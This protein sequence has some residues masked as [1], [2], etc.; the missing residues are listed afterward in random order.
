MSDPWHTAAQILAAAPEHIEATAHVAKDS[1]FFDGHFPDYPVVPGIAMLSM[2]E[3]AVDSGLPGMAVTGFKRVRFRQAVEQGGDFI[4]TLRPSPRWPAERY[5]FEVS[6]GG[7]K[8]CE[9]QVLV[10][11]RSEP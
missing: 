9:G 10:G 7:S 5:L 3:G 1:P 8:A 4:I 11:A 2:V 6:Y